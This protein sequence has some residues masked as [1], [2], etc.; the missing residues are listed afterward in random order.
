MVVVLVHS[1]AASLNSDDISSET[2][3][4]PCARHGIVAVAVRTY[5][6]TEHTSRAYS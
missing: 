5:L 4:I 1:S 6:Q 3:V 2:R